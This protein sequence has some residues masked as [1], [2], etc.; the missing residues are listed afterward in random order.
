MKITK[1]SYRT[2][3]IP[4]EGKY[5]S[6]HVEAEATI[7]K[8]EDP[9]EVLVELAQWVHVQLGITK[10]TPPPKPKLRSLGDE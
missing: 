10:P 7:G 3:A 4:R 9:A 6:K 5:Q 8:D 2:N 1:V